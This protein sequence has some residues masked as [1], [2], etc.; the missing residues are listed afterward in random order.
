MLLTALFTRTVALS[1][2]PTTNKFSFC[3][4]SASEADIQRRLLMARMAIFIDN[5]GHGGGLDDVESRKNFHCAPQPLAI[6]LS[7]TREIPSF[8]HKLKR[9]HKFI[10]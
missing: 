2:L 10:L 1:P 8:Y 9:Y 7:I 3:C 5:P 6:R 4:A